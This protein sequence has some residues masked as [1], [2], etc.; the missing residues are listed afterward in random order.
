MPEYA[1]D[2]QVA[3]VTGAGRGQGRSHARQYAKHGA[4][5]VV[6]DGPKGI[7]TS[8]YPLA[9]AAQLDET[10]SLVEDEGGDA[11]V[12]R[13]DVRRESAVEAAVDEALDR[14]GKIDILANNAGIWNVADLV[15]MDE[16]RWDELVDTVLKGTWLCSKHVGQQFVERGDGGKIVSTASTAGLVGARGSGHY[17][18][19]KHGVVG[20][21]KA[22][23]LELAEHGVNVNAV[24]PTGVA[25]PMIDGILE[26]MGDDALTSVSDASGS[27]N[28]LDDQLIE[29][30]DVSEA[31]MWLS[32]DAARYVTG[33]TL[34]VDAGML[35][36]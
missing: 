10:A 30:R 20:L 14:F 18:A 24:V 29:P 35:A 17:A 5:V 8:Q 25:T 22:L 32:S 16:Q 31:Y 27:M 19:A 1:F 6:V 34:P 28:V 15:A 13:A 33:I 4:D 36:K 21:T 7:E 11:L 12:V 3:F 23:A 9:S 26:T 2:G